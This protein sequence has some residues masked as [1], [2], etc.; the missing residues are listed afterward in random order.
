MT[1]LFRELDYSEEHCGILISL[2][3][4]SRLMHT[5]KSHSDDEGI[6]CSG[7]RALARLGKLPHNNMFSCPGHPYT[8]SCAVCHSFSDVCGSAVC[9][10]VSNVWLC[11][12]GVCSAVCLPSAVV[13]VTDGKEWLST[14]Q[15][16]MGHHHDTPRVQVAGGDCLATLLECC[17]EVKSQLLLMEAAKR[18]Q[19]KCRMA[20]E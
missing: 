9:H 13:T 14:I 6:Q 5:L 1:Q 11:F 16:A 18:Y 19:W 17:P 2:G 4:H 12:V 8:L 7:L 15:S 20:V 3:L 10:S